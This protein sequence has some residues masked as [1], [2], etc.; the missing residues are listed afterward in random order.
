LNEAGVKPEDVWL[1]S[2]NLDDV[3][4]WVDN[5]PAY[6]EQAVYLDSIDPTANPPISR[7]TPDGLTALAAAGVRIFAPPMWALLDVD[8]AGRVVP[9]Q[10]AEDIKSAGLDIITWTFERSDLR[11]GASKAGWYYQF[12]P[13]GKA[14]RKDSD[15]YEALDVLARRVKILGSFQTGRRPSPTMRTAWA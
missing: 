15:M 4:Y 3:L 5:M 2:F 12:D 6:G 1:Q 7:L 14:I 9:S 13:E 10:Y 11:H 8:L